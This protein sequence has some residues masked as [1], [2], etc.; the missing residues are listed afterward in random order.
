MAYTHTFGS[1]APKEGQRAA[2]GTMR[3]D[4]F[5]LALALLAAL[6]A[7]EAQPP[8]KKVRTDRLVLP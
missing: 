5:I 7:A 6:L 4:V 1:T 8:G 2:G 3:L